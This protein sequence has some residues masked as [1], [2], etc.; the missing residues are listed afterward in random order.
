[1]L[2]GS[3]QQTESI[4]CP[5]WPS[6]QATVYGRDSD[7]G[8]VF[9]ESHRAGGN[10]GISPNTIAELERTIS[11][12]SL[13]EQGQRISVAAV[14]DYA[15]T[16]LTTWLVD[17]MLMGEWEPIVTPEVISSVRRRRRLFVHERANRLL[18]LLANET[19]SIGDSIAFEE[20]VTSTGMRPAN[21]KACAW[22]EST[23]WGELEYL[24][25]Y[26]VQNGW[27]QFVGMT[28]FQFPS[29]RVTVDGYAEIARQATATDSAKVFVAMWFDDSM[30]DAYYQGIE[31]AI[32][33]AGYDPV[34]IDSVEHTGQI[35]DAIVAEIRKSRFV[36]ADLTQGDD[37]ARGGVY[38]EAGFANGL[39]LTVIFTCRVDR[40]KLVH[41]DANHQAHILWTDY[42][43]L[44]TRL[45][46]R[47]E[48][49]VGPG[50]LE[51]H[52]DQEEE[53]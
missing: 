29:Y 51:A 46:N 22:S 52:H 19:R 45:R 26:L 28:N 8:T 37:G 24:I 14:S 47:I 53:C 1:M 36:I 34:R 17:Q 9:I 11:F 48:A 31:P 42:A 16:G 12:R 15:R 4:K 49:V 35:E 33:E 21:L 27:L 32:K 30:K 10:Y 38:Y 18:R 2:P 20:S 3:E 43:D 25:D 39:G 6:F 13:S 50:P 40:F 5:I 41:F 7:D 23:S 44:R